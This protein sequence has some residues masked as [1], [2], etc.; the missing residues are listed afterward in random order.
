MARWGLSWVHC[1][2]T[3]THCVFHIDQ[4]RG[5]AGALEGGVLQSFGGVMVHDGWEQ[6]KTVT[7]AT[8][9]LCDAHYAESG[10]GGMG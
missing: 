7:T 3:S 9:G 6:Y 4:K 8:H 10:I 1:A 5:L 2:S